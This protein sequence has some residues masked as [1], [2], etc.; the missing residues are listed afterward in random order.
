MR[1]KKLLVLL[2]F[3]MPIFILAGCSS[4]KDS[5]TQK[6]PNSY[7]SALKEAKGETVT[8][9][10]FGGSDTQNLWIDKVV[11]PMMKDKGITLKRVPMDIDTILNKLTTEKEAGK[12]SGNMDVVWINGENFYNAKKLG[13]LAGP[14]KS[15]LIPNMQKYMDPNDPDVTKDMSTPVDHL[16][17]PYGN[18]QLVMIGSKSMFKGDYPTSADKLMTWAKA[19]PGK[20]TYV[21]PPDFTGSAFIRNIIYETV[22]YKKLNDA[23]A[24][25]EGVYKV[26][27]PSLDYLNEIK[28]Y[29]WQQGKT[30]PKT[31]AQ[32]D[33]MFADHQVA[34]DFSYNQMYAATQKQDGQF[35]DD[36]Q[37]FVFDKGTV[38]N[39]NYL[40]IPKTSKQKAAAIVLINTM[41][42][43]KAQTARLSLKY[44]AVVS[45]YSADKM[46]SAMTD[47]LNNSDDTNNTV[48]VND[49]AKKRLPEVSGKKI[50]I[51]EQ[52]WKEHV[53]NAD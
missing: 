19:N 44:G 40:A 16:E 47:K 29:L 22:G 9:Y 7:K 33:K 12:T 3:L 11:T 31:T 25:K 20:L 49:L 5:E 1:G 8:Y 38:G 23:P 18:A 21:A 35:T 52:L 51:I 2:A 24:T 10:G 45:P 28:P 42:S 50:P 37:S 13:L 17:I 32:L 48:P 36:A 30:Y 26:I 27:K 15:S 14:V 39:F 41:L 4:N 43:E 46:P 6:L 53:L 34:M